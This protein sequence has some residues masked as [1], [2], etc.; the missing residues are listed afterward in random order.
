MMGY[1]ITMGYCINCGNLFSFNPVH[2]PSLRVR[3]VRQPVC[4]H[5]IERANP[6]RRKNGLPEIVPHPDAYEPC[7]ERELP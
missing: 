6:L 3:G 5:C 4:R 2:V 1:A 7:D